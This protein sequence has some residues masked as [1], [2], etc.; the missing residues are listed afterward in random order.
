M[1]FESEMFTFSVKRTGFEMGS[2]THFALCSKFIMPIHKMF[3][4]KLKN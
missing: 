4:V 3:I 1:T 2:D